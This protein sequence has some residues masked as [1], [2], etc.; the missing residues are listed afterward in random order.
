MKYAVEKHQ[1]P[2]EA[3]DGLLAH[4]KEKKDISTAVTNAYKEQYL[5]LRTSNPSQAAALKGQLISI[6]EYL[7]Y[8]GKKKVED[9]EKKQK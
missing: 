7:G 5:Q 1:S 4:G 2:K 8:N 3:L 6:Y 9:W